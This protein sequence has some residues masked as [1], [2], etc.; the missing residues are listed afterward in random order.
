MLGVKKY[1]ELSI[2]LRSVA[3]GDGDVGSR[4]HE[5]ARADHGRGEDV[6][7]GHVGGQHTAC[8]S[9]GNQDPA[10]DPFPHCHFPGEFQV[11]QK[12]FLKGGVFIPLW[13]GGMSDASIRET[14][15]EE[16]GEDEGEEGD[17]GRSH[18]VED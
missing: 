14:H 8:N 17:S 1:K 2:S 11:Q 13:P 5:V 18:Q 6:V 12:L 10:V 4:L 16:G 7:E 15:V 9:Q 3:G